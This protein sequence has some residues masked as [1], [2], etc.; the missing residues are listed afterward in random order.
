M[1]LILSS[2]E[3]QPV[4]VKTTG[5]RQFDAHEPVYFGNEEMG[6]DAFC[7][8]VKSV[9]NGEMSGYVAPFGYE[10]LNPVLAFSA[11]E[12]FTISMVD[13]YM[14]AHY[15]LTNSDIYVPLDPRPTLLDWIQKQEPHRGGMGDPAR[16]VFIQTCQ[17]GA[18][19][20][21]FNPGHLRL[22]IR[23]PRFVA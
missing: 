16:S 19:V 7:E 17:D 2:A 23:V 9:V 6:M 5:C 1:A 4:E 21:G 18:A 12:E 14:M 13:F 22:D 11:S 8:L 10:F 3:P 20:P 15:I